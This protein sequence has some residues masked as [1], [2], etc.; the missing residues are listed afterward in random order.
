LNQTSN[1]KCSVLVVDD[2]EDAATSLGLLLEA[3]GYEVRT[4][5]DGL[6]ALEVARAMQ[7]RALLLD[8]GLPKLNGYDLCR[9]LRQEAWAGDACIVALTGWDQ[10]EDRRQ[11]RAAGFDHHFVKPVD[12][13]RI[14]ELLTTL[15]GRFDHSD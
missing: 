11:A 6:Q 10:E 9:Q 2:N 7:P 1:S 5:N 13:H 8:I 3:F 15:T 14:D 12:P 4:A